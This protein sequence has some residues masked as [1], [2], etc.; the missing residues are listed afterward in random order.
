MSVHSNDHNNH[1]HAI[2][3]YEFQNIVPL[4]KSIDN[5]KATTQYMKTGWRLELLKKLN[6]ARH[7]WNAKEIDGKDS[8]KAYLRE[9]H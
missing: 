1:Q 2:P 6:K 7:I 8:K 9:I 3:T 5:Q 4:Q